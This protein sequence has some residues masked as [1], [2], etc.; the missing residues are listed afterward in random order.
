MPYRT[1]PQGPPAPHADPN[2][3]LC[4]IQKIQSTKTPTHSAVTH[5]VMT[6]QIASPQLLSILLFNSAHS[7]AQ[8]SLVLEAASLFSSA[9]LTRYL[10]HSCT[11]PQTRYL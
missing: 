2:F 10:M 1:K 5:C 11:L 4:T 7:T 3:T 8:L 9:R 6:I